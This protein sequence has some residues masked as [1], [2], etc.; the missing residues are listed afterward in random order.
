[1]VVQE[2]IL[3]SMGLICTYVLLRQFSYTR[4][5]DYLIFSIVFTFLIVEQVIILITDVTFISNFNGG[6]SQKVFLTVQRIIIITT[7]ISWF[8]MFIIAYRSEHKTIFNIRM[9][10]MS[11][12]ALILIIVPIKMNVREIPEFVKL[13]GLKIHSTQDGPGAIYEFS[14]N[15]VFGQGHELFLLIFRTIAS[16]YFLL[17]I[18]RLE[19]ALFYPRF[20]KVRSIWIVAMISYLFSQ[21]VILSIMLFDEQDIYFLFQIFQSITGLLFIAIVIY[22]P[23]GFLLSKVQILRA[24]KYMTLHD[25][26]SVK[27]GL[28]TV[29]ILEYIEYVEQAHLKMKDEL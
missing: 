25:L 15:L 27:Q 2:L 5:K 11:L 16:T 19:N 10:A 9:Y 12:Y 8:G 1:M 18:L 28:I 6:S 26:A 22:A 20:N 21:A 13:V 3:S 17:Q 7:T 23:E 4:I 24:K 14:N 29:K